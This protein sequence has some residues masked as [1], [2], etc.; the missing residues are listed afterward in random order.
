MRITIINSRADPAG[1]NIRR[2]LL[3]MLGTD[4]MRSVLHNTHTLNFME[5][6]GR[7]IHEKG[8]DERCGADLIIFISRHVSVNPMPLLTVHVTGNYRAAELGGKPRSL[9]MASPEWMHAI[10]RRLSDN[11]P[12][13]YRVSYEVTHHGPT[14]LMTPSLF[15][16]I[17]STSN[18]WD[19]EAAG[20]AVA[21]SILEAEPAT[22]TVNLIGF[23]G[24]HNAARQTDI[25]LSGRGAFGHIAHTR[26][27]DTIDGAMV[28]LMAEKSGA[29]AA[30][31]D[32]KSLPAATLR[33]IER[34]IDGSGLLRLTQGEITELGEINWQSYCQIRKLAE[35]IS[36]RCRPHIHTLR[37][38]GRSV[39]FGIIP[40]LL[41]E[42]LK[43]NTPAFMKE[44]NALPVVHLT[45]SKSPVLPVF[46]S[47]EEN[48]LQIIHD[49]ITLCVKII[50][51]DENTAA[52]GNDL[53]IRKMRFDPQKACDLGV[54]E[55]PLFG[56]LAAGKEIKID[57]H[58]ISPSM[59]SA[60]SE[61][62]IHVP[63]LEKYI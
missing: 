55:G 5:V 61:R 8:L 45:S 14:D 21:M 26:E 13:G 32:R 30:Y 15:V 1:V 36:P 43:L 63:G 34:L 54:P 29:V 12:F 60:C 6:D 35:E 4:G 51:S 49:L 62:V 10:L 48:K 41:S 3:E 58:V 53:I 37:G 20:M 38:S 33:H 17:G 11:A 42:T 18:E 27:T 47:Y 50:N 56:R 24:N 44:L 7:L 39:S 59:V 2:N 23:G 46:I 16:E 25:A 52:V 57:G 40:E 19:D 22:D 28:C 31:I 9:A